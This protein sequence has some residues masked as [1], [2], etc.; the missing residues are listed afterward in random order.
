MSMTNSNSSSHKD[1]HARFAS[2][3]PDSLHQ[4]A[5]GNSSKQAGEGGDAPESPALEPAPG[6][7]PYSRPSTPKAYH[8]RLAFVG[9]GNMGSQMAKNLAR[10]LHK[11]DQPPLTV[12][13]R[14]ADKLEAFKKMADDE[15]IPY[16]VAKDLK[17][18]AHRCDMI[19]TSLGSDAA[20]EAVYAEL[21]AGVEEKAAEREKEGYM[22]T[23]SHHGRS[24]GSRPTI[25]VDTSTVYPDTAGK[26]ERQCSANRHG[27]WISSPV[28]GPPPLAAQAGLVL[29][30]SG[31]YQAK[32]HVA[33]ALV[34]AI[35]RKVMDL[36]SNVERAM[37]FKL[38]GNSMVLGSEFRRNVRDG[39]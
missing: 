36:G 33:H 8:D 12:W 30:I 16:Q 20:V 39:K 3:V 18:V 34:P 25:F 23:S 2:S 26:L 6:A 4:A 11:Q 15:G 35:G 27:A 38:V 31:S 1:L 32:K 10:H 37:A 22:Q 29:A 9:L 5:M 19:V 24:G 21:F 7:I 28:F 13:N 14:S 17:E